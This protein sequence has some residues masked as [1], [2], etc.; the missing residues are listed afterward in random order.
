MNEFRGGVEDRRDTKCRSVLLLNW[1]MDLACPRILY[2]LDFG[3]LAKQ[4]SFF[5]PFLFYNS[6]DVLASFGRPALFI[7]FPPISSKGAPWPV[8]WS[9]CLSAPL[10]R[11]HL[12]VRATFPSGKFLPSVGAPFFSQMEHPFFHKCHLSSP[13]FFL[14]FCTYPS[15][16]PLCVE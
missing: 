13:T 4:N 14:K 10:L 16:H 8:R 2:F 3:P 5:F 7:G 1:Y 15:F 9:T 6:L 12:P 11:Q